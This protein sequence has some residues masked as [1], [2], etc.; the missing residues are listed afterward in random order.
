MLISTEQLKI[1]KLKRQLNY[2]KQMTYDS[3]IDKKNKT[4][5]NC[6]YASRTY[7]KF[8]QTGIL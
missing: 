4:T 7:T 5:A 6:V 8:I 2:N 3:F 1:N